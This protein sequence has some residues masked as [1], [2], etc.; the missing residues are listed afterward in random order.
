VSHLLDVKQWFVQVFKRI[1]PPRFFLLVVLRIIL[2]VLRVVALMRLLVAMRVLLLL[3]LLML[4]A[5]VIRSREFVVIRRSSHCGWC[6]RGGE[7]SLQPLCVVVEEVSG[8]CEALLLSGK[9]GNAAVNVG[10]W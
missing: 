4:M 9:V 6:C 1:K 10:G 5:G 2:L 8:I 7:P 3:L